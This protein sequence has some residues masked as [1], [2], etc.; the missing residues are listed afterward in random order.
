MLPIALGV[1]RLVRRGKRAREPLDL[2]LGDRRAGRRDVVTAARDGRDADRARRERTRQPQQ[3][4]ARPLAGAVGL[5]GRGSSTGR[6]SGSTGPDHSC[7]S[8]RI[9]GAAAPRA[10]ERSA[11][12]T[13][14]PS[15]AASAA[16]PKSP[17]DG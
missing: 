7:S 10:T 6:S 4:P 5:D 13:E 2:G 1:L 14:R 12:V 11:S 16:R 17:A 15:A 3:Q 8:R 9:V